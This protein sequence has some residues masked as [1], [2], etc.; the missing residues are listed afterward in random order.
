MKK[1]P[2]YKRYEGV[3]PIGVQAI[4]NCFGIALFEPD[5]IDKYDCEIV[6]AWQNEEGYSGFRKHMI[7]YTALGRGFIRKG[8]M[9]I[10]LDEV[11]KVA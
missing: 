10:Y 7:H 9:R 4:T 2:M 11:V 1:Q 3:T 8:G 5:A 6:A